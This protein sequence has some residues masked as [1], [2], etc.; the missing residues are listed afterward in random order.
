MHVLI[1]TYMPYRRS[2]RHTF[3]HHSVIKP[4][5]LLYKYILERTWPVTDGMDP[6]L[7]LVWGLLDDPLE[8]AIIHISMYEY[9]QD[10]Q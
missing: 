4:Y 3:R 1:D 5:N 8:P 9:I 6:I 7:E 2:S 10:S